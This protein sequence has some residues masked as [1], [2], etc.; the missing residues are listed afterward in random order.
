MRVLSL[1]VPINLEHEPDFM[2]NRLPA[3]EKRE[4]QYWDGSRWIP[5]KK[6]LHAVSGNWQICTVQRVL[7]ADSESTT[8]KLL[9]VR[10]FTKGK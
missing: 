1:E 3:N 2:P 7:Q 10:N 8:M 9:L 5:N 6:E 4:W